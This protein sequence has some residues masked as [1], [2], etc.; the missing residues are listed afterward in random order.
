MR[1]ILFLLTALTLCSCGPSDTMRPEDRGTRLITLPNGKDIRVEVRSNPEDILRGAM[2]RESL[3]EERGFLMRHAKA[4]PLPT[5]MYQVKFPL[6]LL[7]LD[8]NGRIVEIVHS[9]PPCPPGLTARQCPVYGSMR[10]NARSVLQLAGGVAKKQGLTIG[11]RL[12][13]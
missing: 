4:G 9:A 7:W 8:D 11:T 1:S 5:F 6:D 2:F 12:D 3:P 13:L 10:A